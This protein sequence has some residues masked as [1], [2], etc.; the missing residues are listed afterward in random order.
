MEKRILVIENNPF[1]LELMSDLLIRFGYSVERVETGGEALERLSHYEFDAIF[2]DIHLEDINGKAVYQ[3]LKERS[4]GQAQR[5]IFVTGD[6]GNTETEVFLKESGNLWL[7]K[8]FTLK[9]IEQ[10]L[11]SFFLDHDP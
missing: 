7:P 1:I 2:L 3:K 8:P 4:P 9:E 10:I 11:A 5:V 6:L